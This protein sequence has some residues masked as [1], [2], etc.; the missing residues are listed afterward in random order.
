[1][2]RKYLFIMVLILMLLSITGCSKVADEKQM[3]LDLESD[4]QFDFLKDEEKIEELVIEKRQT[5]KKQKLDTIWCTVTTA[6]EGISYQKEVILTYGLYDKGWILDNVSVNDYKQWIQ[7]PIEGIAEDVISASLNGQSITIDGEEWNITTGNIK[8]ISIDNH[9]TDLDKKTDIVTATLTLEEEVEEAKGKLTIHYL[10]DN[11][12]KI[13]TVST[14]EEFVT[15]IKSE[16]ALEVTNEDLIAHVSEQSFVLRAPKTDGVV[17][18][19]AVEE[20]MHTVTI[21]SSE[22]SNFAIEN[23]ESLFKGTQQI[24]HCQCTL[25]KPYVVFNLEIEIPYRYHSGE[26]GLQQLNITPQCASLNIVGEWTGTYRDAPFGGEARLKISDIDENGF[27]TAVYSYYPSEEDKYTDPGSYN[28][29]GTIDM[30]TLDMNLIAGEW[31]EEPSHWVH[32]WTKS[33]VSGTLCVDEAVIKG[34]GQN[35]C[36]FV[37]TK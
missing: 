30:S 31:I 33:D 1:M 21:N 17:A 6:K 14:S 3:Q 12:W 36:P 13:E 26:W 22:I 29:S 34:T 10:F 23:Q 16:A 32:S 15:S 25:T 5:D 8:N 11:G 20:A 28:V 35:G 24:Y 4:I 2:K 37:I 9:D 18:Y 19:W 7:T 27:I